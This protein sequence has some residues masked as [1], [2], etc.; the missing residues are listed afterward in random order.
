[1][2]KKKLKKKR[3]HDCHAIS[4][5][6]KA[7]NP[8]PQNPPGTSL[9]SQT[10]LDRMRK[11]QFFVDASWVTRVQRRRAQDYGSRLTEQFTSHGLKRSEH[12]QGSTERYLLGQNTTCTFLG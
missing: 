10:S 7:G 12:M 5:A 9:Y 8:E 1:M 6:A 4:T 3:K 11:M 2:V